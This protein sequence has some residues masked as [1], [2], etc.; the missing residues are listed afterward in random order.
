M[1]IVLDGSKGAG[2]SSVSEILLQ[3]IE[4]VAFLSFDNERKLLPVRDKMTSGVH[5]EPFENIIKKAREF[6]KSGKNLVIDCGL[7]KGRVLELEQ[8]ALDFNT[9]LYKFLLKASY[10][11]LLGRVVSRD[12]AKG[13]ETN[14]ERFKEVHDIVY[15]K[16][17]K[18]FNII[19]TDELKI[20]EVA[21]KVLSMV[22]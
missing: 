14:L 20:E 16:E 9:K 11:T 18:D 8:M 12:Q 7:T 22:N 13:Q 21:G 4:N 5:T 1:I 3:K 2:K 6:L 19:E 10:E 17:F 15:L